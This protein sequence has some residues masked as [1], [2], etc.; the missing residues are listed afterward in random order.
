[1]PCQGYT[2]MYTYV[3]IGNTCS[4]I[5][6]TVFSFYTTVATMKCPGEGR[7]WVPGRKQHPH[8]TVHCRPGEGEILWG[9][10][11]GRGGLWPTERSLCNPSAC[12]KSACHHPGPCHNEQRGD[13]DW[14]WG[15]GVA[16]EGWRITGNWVGAGE[17]RKGK[18]DTNSSALP[19][20]SS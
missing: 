1:M 12:A 6:D 8:G 3:Y 15:G 4:Q 13:G 14:E 5:L 18:F 9:W 16:R 20:K 7:W 19:A 17:Q 2:Y 11:G 10:G